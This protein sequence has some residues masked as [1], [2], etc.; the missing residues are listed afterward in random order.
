QR[1]VIEAAGEVNFPFN[2]PIREIGTEAVSQSAA[3]PVC[4]HCAPGWIAARPQDGQA[5]QKNDLLDQVKN[6][7][8]VLVERFMT[9]HVLPR[10][11]GDNVEVEPPDE[12]HREI[13][14]SQARGASVL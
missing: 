6:I 8:I 12:E 14:R 11:D 9:V 3:K 13:E 7:E 1:H 4:I 10:N 5:A 2:G